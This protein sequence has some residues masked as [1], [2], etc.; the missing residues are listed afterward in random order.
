M[1]KA[2]TGETIARLRKRMKLSQAKF[3]AKLKVAPLTVSRWEGGKNAIS[4]EMAERVKGLS[5]EVY[6]R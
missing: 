4:P 5:A 6:A 2:I 1:A 3:A